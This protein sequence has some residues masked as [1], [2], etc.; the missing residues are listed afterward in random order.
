MLPGKYK[1]LEQEPG[2]RIL[3]EFIKIYGTQETIGSSDNPTIMWWAKSI[4]LE[5]EYIHDSIPWCGLT[6]AYVAAQA[7]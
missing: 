2:P 7:E 1:W 5:D 3:K 6:V 4:G